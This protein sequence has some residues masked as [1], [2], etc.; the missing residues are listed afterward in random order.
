MFMQNSR[1]HLQSKS[2]AVHEAKLPSPA[3]GFTEW[4]D[5][6]AGYMWLGI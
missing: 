1:D 4:F 5:I 6:Q 3:S 2:N